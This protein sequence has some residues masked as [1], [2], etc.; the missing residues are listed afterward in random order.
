MGSIIEL[1]Q[2]TATPSKDNIHF[3]GVCSWGQWPVYSQCWGSSL[4]L[5][6]FR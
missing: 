6:H 2:M 4:E 1:L 5:L 3:D